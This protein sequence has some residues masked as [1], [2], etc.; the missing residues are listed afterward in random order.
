MAEN[1]LLRQQLL[2]LNRQSDKPKF[3]PV[4]RLW[5]VIFA[6]LVKS[7]RE[8]LLIIKPDTLLKWHRGGFKLFWKLKSKAKPTKRQPRISQETIGLIKKMAS[9]NPIWGAERIRGEL[10]KLNLKVAKR[11]I[12]KYM[13]QA[14]PAPLPSQSWRTFLKNH[15][16]PIWPCHFLPVNDIF[17]RQLYAF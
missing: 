16:S 6:S 2:V 13:R 12:Q 8:A 1:A 5:L 10:I 14:K 9:E 7:W 4:D 17:F 11:N 3:Q 15:A